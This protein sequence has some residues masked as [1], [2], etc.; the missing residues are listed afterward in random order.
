MRNRL[1]MPSW[2]MQTEQK[3]HSL[4]INMTTCRMIRRLFNVIIIGQRAQQFQQKIESSFFLW[5]LP[6]VEVSQARFPHSS[7]L[8]NAQSSWLKKKGSKNNKFPLGV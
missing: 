2:Y 7:V 4:I 6:V 5:V 1:D 8:H 3:L